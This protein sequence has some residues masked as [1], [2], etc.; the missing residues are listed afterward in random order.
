MITMTFLQTR[1]DAVAQIVWYI[2][3]KILKQWNHKQGKVSMHSCTSS[4]WTLNCTT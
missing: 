1:V 3:I 2:I 4:L